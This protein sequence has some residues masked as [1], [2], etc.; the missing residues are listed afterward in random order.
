MKALFILFFANKNSVHWEKSMPG[1][2]CWH[3]KYLLNPIFELMV[4]QIM[5]R[6]NFSKIFILF[7]NNWCMTKEGC[8]KIKSINEI[9]NA[10]LESRGDLLLGR[11]RDQKYNIIKWEQRPEKKRKLKIFTY[12]KKRFGIWT[13]GANFKSTV[14][15]LKRNQ[16]RIH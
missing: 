5:R 4:Y 3:K 15:F 13:K 9:R 2:E 7:E 1:K 10:A 6:W 14:L 11:Q 12:S 16:L 8:L